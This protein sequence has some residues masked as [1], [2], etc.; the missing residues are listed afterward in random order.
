MRKA[1]IK[2]TFLY[3]L[4][5]IT[6]IL[7]TWGIIFPNAKNKKVEQNIIKQSIIPATTIIPSSSSDLSYLM[8]IADPNLDMKLLDTN[9]NQISESIIQ[10]PITDPV[11]SKNKNQPIKEL[12]LQK[13]NTGNYKLIT[14]SNINKISK[15]SIYFY[16][17]NGNIFMTERKTTGTASFDIYFNKKNSKNSYVKNK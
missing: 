8:I 11:S 12:N 10:Q 15:I 13:P 9:G 2:L 14:S 1:G 4:L 5:G 3:I 6:I 17:I 7:V 16:D